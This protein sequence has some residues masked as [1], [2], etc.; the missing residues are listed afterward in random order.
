MVY[1]EFGS[2]WREK[3]INIH[4]W[5]NLMF[6]TDTG[7]CK[8]A[9]LGGRQSIILA[10][11]DRWSYIEGLAITANISETLHPSGPNRTVGLHGTTVSL[12]LH[13]HHLQNNRRNRTVTTAQSRPQGHVQKI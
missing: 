2:T 3:L 4:F 5:H 12:S 6:H 13:L 10:L 11:M 9:Q 1:A 7:D 8:C